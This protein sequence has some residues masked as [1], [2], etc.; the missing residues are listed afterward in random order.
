MAVFPISVCAFGGEKLCTL[1]GCLH[2]H[3]DEFG[4]GAVEGIAAPEAANNAVSGGAMIP[5]L[6]LGIPG[7]GATAILLGAL[8]IK[9][10]A[11]GPTLFSSDMGTVYREISVKWTGGFD[12]APRY[13]IIVAII[14]ENS[15]ELSPLNKLYPVNW[16]ITKRKIQ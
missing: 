14:I 2:K 12:G 13:A 1:R 15:R 8:M 5:M 9:G 10:I 7:D 3:K 11:P 6:S 16:T 4:K